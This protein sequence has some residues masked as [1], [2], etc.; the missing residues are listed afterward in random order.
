M[1]RWNGRVFIAVASAVG[2]A[3]SAVDNLACGGEVSPIVIVLLL[4]L[5]AGALGAARPRA[6]WL[7]VLAV[8]AGFS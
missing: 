2:L 4:A 5:S 7:L 3:V 6:A 1:K 8:G